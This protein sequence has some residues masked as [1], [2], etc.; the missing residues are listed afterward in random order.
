[1]MGPISIR[2]AYNNLKAYKNYKNKIIRK[3][4][5]QLYFYL[6]AEIILTSKLYYFLIFDFTIFY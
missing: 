5:I 3:F 4:P 2:I 1:M 6:I